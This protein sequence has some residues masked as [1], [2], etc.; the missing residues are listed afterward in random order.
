MSYTAEDRLLVKFFKDTITKKIDMVEKSLKEENSTLIVTRYI[1]SSST[2]VRFYSTKDDKLKLQYT[3][4]N[5]G[6]LED[7]LYFLWV[8]LKYV[9]WEG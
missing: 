6:D 7:Q 2:T 9:L 4:L 5:L 1:G 3:F 8:Q